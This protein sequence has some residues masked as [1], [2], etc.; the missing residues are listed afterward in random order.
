MLER[1]VGGVTVVPFTDFT[2]D[3]RRLQ[4]SRDI[5]SKCTISHAL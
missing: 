3:S 5:M 4:P 2:Q 1:A